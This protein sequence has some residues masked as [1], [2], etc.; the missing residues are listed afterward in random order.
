MK[1]IKDYKA[2]L[3]QYKTISE[4]YADE[5]MSKLRS[6]ADKKIDDVEKRLSDVLEDGEEFKEIITPETKAMDKYSH[7]IYETM[8]ETIGDLKRPEKIKLTTLNKYTN[9]FRKALEDQDKVLVK[10]VKLLKDR[11]Y[12]GRV[13][14]LDK[15]LKRMIKDLSSLENFIQNDYAPEADVETAAVLIDETIGQ[16]DQYEDAYEKILEKKEKILE[17]DQEIIELKEK[18]EHMKNHPVKNDLKDAQEAYNETQRDIDHAF[19]NVRKAFRKYEKYL[20]KSRDNRDTTLLSNLVTDA[21]STLADASSIKPVRSLLN[22]M[23]EVLNDAALNLK[24]DKRENAKEDI[25]MFL[26][27]K[28]NELYE[29]STQIVKKRDEAERKLKEMDLENKIKRNETTLA[30]AKRDRNRILRRELRALENI[31]DQ[32]NDNIE[33]ITSKLRWMTGEEISFN[34][35]VPELPSWAEN[36]E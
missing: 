12:K 9:D 22:E 17:K 14:S 23:Y 7:K 11:R 36:K 15:S 28:L 2:E 1:E 18:L 34:A 24:K 31:K 27:G 13:K 5:E 6:K 25:E 8:N 4:K 19:S 21:A 32:I 30:A 16:L 33:T 35:S 26:N 10:Y 29:R 20:S 3:E